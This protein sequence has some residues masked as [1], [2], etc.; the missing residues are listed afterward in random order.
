MRVLIF[1]GSGFLGRYL[2]EEGLSRGYDVHIFDKKEPLID[3][4]YTEGDILNEQQVDKSV[5]WADIVF[6]LTAM[7]DIDDCI[8]NPKTAIEVNVLGN[9]NVM[10]SCVKH[11]VKRFVFASSA[12][13]GGNHGGIYSTTKK[14]NEMLVR[15]YHKFYGLEYTVLRYGTLY[16]VGA[17]PTN[18]ICKYLT[19]AVK[20]GKIDYTGDGSEVREYIHVEDASKMSFDILE[21]KK[22]LSTIVSLT[23]P[24]PTK[25]SDLFTMIKEI[26]N[27]EIDINF[28]KTL[29]KGRTAT[30]YRVSPYTYER[31]KVYKMNL[32]VNRDL[33]DT[34]IEILHDL[35]D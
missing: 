35:D 18:S 29:T 20:Q 15:D 6:N 31:D 11:K 24:N 34:L 21:D 14:S 32:D 5:E 28:N 16:G 22:Y 30:H 4:P 17:P 2:A 12:Y 8:E 3:I 7:S 33:G 25:T 19:Q 23:G 9:V 1:G 10:N 13:A 26:M 27:G